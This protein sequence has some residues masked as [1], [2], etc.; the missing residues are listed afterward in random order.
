M[1]NLT[2]RKSGNVCCLYLYKAFTSKIGIQLKS[3]FTVFSQNVHLVLISLS[4][5]LQ[6]EL[7][8]LL[9]YFSKQFLVSSSVSMTLAQL[10]DLQYG[11]LS[12]ELLLVQLDR[13]SYFVDVPDQQNSCILHFLDGIILPDLDFPAPSGFLDMRESYFDSYEG[14]AQEDVDEEQVEELFESKS[15]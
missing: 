9:Q 15:K 8:D 6:P 3:L 13:Q 5:T 2:L 7:D 14:Q 10:V 1:L 11:V 4:R 12:Q